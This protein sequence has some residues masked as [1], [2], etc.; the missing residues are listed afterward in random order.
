MQS[1]APNPSRFMKPGSRSRPS[2]TLWAVI[3]AVAA[4]CLMST[5]AASAFA[6]SYSITDLGNL[7]YPTARAAGINESGQV[8]GTSY[9]AE[10]VEYNV[11]CV[12]RH[13]PCFVAP[14]AP[15]LVE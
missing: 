9:L 2:R 13:R 1:K 8:A 14:R 5:G 7:G 11:G 10:R 15:V 6:G 3:A 12:P 4:G